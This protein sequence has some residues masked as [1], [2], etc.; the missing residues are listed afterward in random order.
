MN[1]IQYNLHHIPIYIYIYIVLDTLKKQLHSDMLT[2]RAKRSREQQV[3]SR[4]N[5]SELA[6][7]YSGTSTCKK[8]NVVRDIT[9]NVHG[10]AVYVCMYI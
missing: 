3:Q 8:K 6:P 4:S 2:G 10:N 7:K 1:I 5:T 9:C